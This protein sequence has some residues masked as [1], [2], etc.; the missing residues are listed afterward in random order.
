MPEV[1]GNLRLPAVMPHEVIE[2]L[3]ATDLKDGIAKAAD[4]I[5]SGR[6]WKKVEQVREFTRSQAVARKPGKVLCWTGG[7][8]RPNLI[9]Q[10]KVPGIEKQH[11][12]QKPIRVMEW[13]LTPITSPGHVVLDPFMGSGTTGVAALRMGR[14]FVGIERDPTYYQA[15][16]NRLRAELDQGKLF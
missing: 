8:T 15:A 11:P 9:Q 10:S 5:D 2:L 13:C 16:E 6:A 4:E 14:S 3:T 12:T 7:G 1:F